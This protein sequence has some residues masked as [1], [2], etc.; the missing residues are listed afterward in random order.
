MS[1]A[2]PN[3][4]LED[5]Y[6][7]DEVS[8]TKLDDNISSCAKKTG[9][10]KPGNCNF[11]CNFPKFIYTTDDGG[12]KRPLDD[13]VRCLRCFHFN[14]QYVEDTQLFSNVINDNFAYGTKLCHDCCLVF[15]ESK[16]HSKTGRSQRT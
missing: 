11:P 5:R 4:S 15:Y 7:N 8:C 2:E 6:N 3:Y 12:T 1:C 10:S 16:L 14:C 9:L 13:C